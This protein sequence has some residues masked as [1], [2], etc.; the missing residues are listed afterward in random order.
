MVKVVQHAHGCVQALGR[1]AGLQALGRQLVHAQRGR[2]VVGQRRPGDRHAR[3]RR[4]PGAAAGLQ[5]PID[6]RP[7]AD[8][9]VRQQAAQHDVR[10]LGA[11]VVQVGPLHRGARQV[12]QHVVQD[13]GRGLQQPPGVRVHAPAQAHRQALALGQRHRQLDKR[14]GAACAVHAVVEGPGIRGNVVA[15]D[16]IDPLNRVVGQEEHALVVAV[17]DRRQRH[18]APGPGQHLHVAPSA[19]HGTG[20]QRHVVRQR[21]VGPGLQAH[22][23]LA[24]ELQAHGDAVEQHARLRRHAHGAAHGR[25]L[26]PQKGQLGARVVQRGLHVACGSSGYARNRQRPLNAGQPRQQGQRQA[27]GGDAGDAG[28]HHIDLAGGIAAI[29]FE[30]RRHANTGSKSNVADIRRHASLSGW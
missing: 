25:A 17:L 27:R 19:P 22:A 23:H 21:P 7:D 18:M 20:A 8:A 15:L 5:Q 3:H 14:H 2:R 10:G 13:L 4:R 9:V 28:G 29:D 11:V 26:A 24:A 12:R 16:F 6:G 30:P 1:G